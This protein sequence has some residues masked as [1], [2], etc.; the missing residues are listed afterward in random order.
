LPLRRDLSEWDPSG[1]GRSV[2]PVRLPHDKRDAGLRDDAAKDRLEVV[3]TEL[4]Q[5]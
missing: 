4:D 3:S 5:L 1:S 2:P